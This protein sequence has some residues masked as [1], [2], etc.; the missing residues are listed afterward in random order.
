MTNVVGIALT[1]M[2]GHFS[3]EGEGYFTWYDA[4]AACNKLVN[5]G[6]SDWL[7]PNRWQLNQLYLH[8]DDVGGFAGDGYWCSSEFSADRSWVQDF[9]NG[10]QIQYNKDGKWR[11]R[12]IRAF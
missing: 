2:R 1:D 4:K 10:Y 8:N 3:G 6:Y 7:I 12:P 9:S 5:N 11:V